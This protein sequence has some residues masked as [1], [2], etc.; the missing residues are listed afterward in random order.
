MT[1]IPKGFVGGLAPGRQKCLG[2]RK[3]GGLG[4][5]FLTVL[6]KG[7]PCLGLTRSA[8]AAQTMHCY[9]DQLSRR[10]QQCVVVM[11]DWQ[12]ACTP[13]ELKGRC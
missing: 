5:G 9:G 13:V 4:K 6:N 7:F 11:Q 3:R 12:I 1:V 10:S 2:S 8:S